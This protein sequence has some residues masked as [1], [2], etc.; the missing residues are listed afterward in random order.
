MRKAFTLIELMISIV[1]L[2]TMMVFLYKTYASLNRS[3]E[4]IKTE[5]HN[6]KDIQQLKKV[7]Y[8]DFSL[9]LPKTMII[10]NRE[11]VEDAVFFQ[12]SNSIHKRYN[13]Y[14]TYIVKENKL[15]RLES[16]TKFES[17]ELPVNAE[18]DVDYLGEVDKFR[19]YKSSATDTEI[20]LLNIGFKEFGD[21]LLKVRVL[22][23]Y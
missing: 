5:L 14:I 2:S 23:E 7:L 1:I 15:Y 11:T 9:A 10:Q 12:S 16:L 18:F 19:V 13:P 20:Y 6:I 4:V 3:N 21:V 17:Y 8:L 22:N